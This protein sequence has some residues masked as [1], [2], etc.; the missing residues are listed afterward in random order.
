MVRRATYD[1]VG[2]YIEGGT[3]ANRTGRGA[4]RF[5][6]T[7][8]DA[9]R[10]LDR[11][12]LSVA[13]RTVAAMFRRP[14]RRSRRR[15][16]QRFIAPARRAR[17]RVRSPFPRV[18]QFRRVRATRTEPR[19]APPVLPA[20]AAHKPTTPRRSSAAARLRRSRRCRNHPARYSELSGKGCAARLA[21]STTLSLASTVCA[22][23]S[24]P[25]HT[26]KAALVAMATI[27]MATATSA[28]VVPRW[29]SYRTPGAVPHP[30][31]AS[32]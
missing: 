15:F 31:A 7:P 8:R 32:T 4:W 17:A 5:G 26:A 23:T 3:C 6:S 2:A 22:A 21:L 9:R 27:A 24:N 16:P 11:A 25:Q 19:R 14:V 29:R 10:D 30:A 18:R 13:H 1:N 20:P 12:P 28:S